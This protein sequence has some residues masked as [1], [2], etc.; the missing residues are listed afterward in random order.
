LENRYDVKA[1]AIAVEQAKLNATV[2]AVN[3]VPTISFSESISGSPPQNVGLSSK[4]MGLAF[5]DPSISGRFSISIS[6]PITPWIPGSSQNISIKTAG[7]KK[8][9]ETITLDALKK[10]AAQDIKKKVDEI[11]RITENMGSTELNYR[12]AQRAFELSQQGYRGG[13]VSQTDLQTANQRMVNANQTVVTAKIN[14][15]T[16]VYNLASSLSLDVQEL[17][18]LYAIKKE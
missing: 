3:K 8:G 16:A 6:I 12:I 14:Y 5:E 9:T 1:Q 17:Y 11:E 7:E 15:L 13:L 10:S 2:E 4:N 18:T